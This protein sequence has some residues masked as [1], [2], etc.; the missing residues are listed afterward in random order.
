MISI[1]YHPC[2]FATVAFWDA[3]NFARGQQPPPNEWKPAP[4]RTATQMAEGLQRFDQ[5]LAHIV[6]QPGVEVLTGRQILN[7]LPD[8]AADRLLTLAELAPLLSFPTDAIEH[9]FLD[10][11]TVLAPSELFSL[12]VEALVQ[13]LMMVAEDG[14]DAPLDLSQIQIAV[15]EDTPLGPVR[16]Q[17][18]TMTARTAIPIEAF[19][20]AAIDARQYLQHHA[21]MPDAIWLGSEA[22]APADYLMTAANLLTKLNDLSRSRSVSVPTSIALSAAFLAS[23]R[24]VGDK[25][26]GWVVFPKDFDAP[27]LIELARLQTWTLKPALLLS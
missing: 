6:D 20:E 10:A 14:A 12:V 17:A 26:W 23:E 7:H 25:V 2:E 16:R 4:L 24:H 27:N 5:Y 11:E 1:Y 18:S 15:D 21:R 3:V 19:L 13:I 9:R 22:L 8:Q